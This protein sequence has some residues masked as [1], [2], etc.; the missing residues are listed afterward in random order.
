MPAS[1]Y[2]KLYLH[3]VGFESFV[4]GASGKN[5]ASSNLTVGPIKSSS[6]QRRNQQQALLKAGTFPSKRERKV[7]T[8]SYLNHSIQQMG[9]VL[10]PLKYLNFFATFASLCLKHLLL[11]RATAVLGLTTASKGSTLWSFV[12]LS[13]ARTLHA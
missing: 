11:A 9:S 6:A 10:C 3:S 1:I 4:M 13:V 8:D 12:P 2:F 7:K 5:Q